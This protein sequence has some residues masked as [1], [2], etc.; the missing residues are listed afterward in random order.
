MIICE[1]NEKR[2]PQK[3]LINV[4]NKGKYYTLIENIAITY[5][6][7]RAKLLPRKKTL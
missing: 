2:K 1:K 6:F 4:L 7:F 5:F 3:V